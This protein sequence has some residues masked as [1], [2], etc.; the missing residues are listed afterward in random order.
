MAD[1]SKAIFPSVFNSL[2]PKQDRR[3]FADAI[4]KLILLNENVWISIK[5][6]HFTEVSS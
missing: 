1:I 3:H 4:F 6:S 5:I 2:M